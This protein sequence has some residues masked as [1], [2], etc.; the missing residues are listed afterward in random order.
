MYPNFLCSLLLGTLL[1]A[2]EVAAGN[3]PPANLPPVIVGMVEMP[4]YS[5]YGEDGAPA[6]ILLP[7]MERVLKRAGYRAEFRIMPVA[8]LVQGMQDGSLDVWPGLDNRADLGGHTLVG[9][10]T[11]GH[12]NINLY[13]R[14]DTPE[15]RWPQDLRG[16][17]LI[18]ISGL[19]YWPPLMDTIQDPANGMRVQRTVNHAGA[20]GMLIRKRGN[21][22]LNYET[23]MQEA[24]AQ[25]PDLQL[26]S[27]PLKRAPLKMV[28]SKRASLG[29]QQLLN[30]LEDAY[31][32]LRA[33][34][35]LQEL[36][37]Y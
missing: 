8:R 22:L 32:S 25:R 37:E 9:A 33:E 15:P 30:Q 20:I 19:A 17:D 18:L 29:G 26:Q 5:V 12:V 14:Q 28:V 16:E 36:P 27:K 34:K 7:V 6:G 2:A 35:A 4:P 11:L 13:Y 24:L 3:A 31:Q 21:Y 1:L 23:P 10:S